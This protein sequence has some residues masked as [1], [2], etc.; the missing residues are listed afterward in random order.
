MQKKFADTIVFG[1]PITVSSFLSQT[2]KLADYSP[3]RCRR[4]GSEHATQDTTPLGLSKYREIRAEVR[5]AWSYY[6]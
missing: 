1:N 3:D 6:E 5:E 2:A 4:G